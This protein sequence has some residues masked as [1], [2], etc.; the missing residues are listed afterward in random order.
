MKTFMICIL[1]QKLFRRM[2]WAGH[3]AHGEEKK[4]IKVLVGKHYLDDIAVDRMIMINW[5]LKK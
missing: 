3:A 1:H 5:V 2:R 4:C